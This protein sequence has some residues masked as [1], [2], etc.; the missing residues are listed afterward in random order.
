MPDIRDLA[1]VGDRRTAAVLDRSGNLVW[2]CPERFDRPSLFAGLL[3][4]QGGS[5]RL[6]L[7]DA[8][9]AGRR[10]LGDSGVLE[11]RLRTGEAEWVV[12]DF[13][14]AG[15]GVPHGALCRLFSAPPQEARAIVQPRPDYAR[16]DATLTPAGDAVAVNGRQHLYAS[17]PLTIEDGSVCLVLPGGAQG[18]MILADAPLASP[19]RADL[20]QW[21]NAT[22]KHWE[23]LSKMASYAGPY[24]REVRASLRA[25]RLLCH[26]E[27]GGII[28]AATTSLPEVVGGSGNWDYRYVW[29]RDAGMI[30]SALTRLE[31]ELTEGERYLDFICGSRG[32]SNEYPV[33]VFTTLDG[34]TAPE[35]KSLD[36]AGYGGSRPV[37]IGNGARDQMQL[38]GFA[39][40]LLA[41]KLIY[42]RSGERPHWN[43][44]EEIAKFLVRHWREPDHGM[45]EEKPRRQYT[46]SKVI[47][48][49]ALDSVAG[50]VR[51][52]AQAQRWRQAVQEIRAFV[53]EN[54]MT[55]DGAYAAV[56]GGEEVDVSAA[57]FPAWAYTDPDAPEMR[58]TIAA[59]EQHWSWRGLLYWRRLECADSRKEGAFLA[60]TFWVAQYWALRGDLQRARHIID[61]AL[62]CA[63]DLG[64]FAE[65]ADPRAGR[66]LGN[67]PQAF[68]HA[69]FI[70]AVIDLRAATESSKRKGADHD[71]PT[72]G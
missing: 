28:A 4:P 34:K 48:A 72:K 38:D 37:R 51:D 7:R 67:I 26:E 58:A 12:T 17:H 24:E 19:A 11:T 23:D 41:A 27:T 36:L 70:G 39:N 61:A 54:C 56:A 66:M 49:R 22:L 29:L 20:H 13:M 2:Y 64:L 42:R 71:R 43:T 50:Y 30:V 18:W 6:E 1:V 25:I 21:L 52:H 9:P 60:G 63:N 14:P 40:V 62:A 47:A 33:A 46:A 8:R 5:W 57:L 55:S 59:L 68:V 10:Y 15:N 65:E 44:V 69:A 32:S 3:D 16:E 35:E 53:A 31:G 45:W